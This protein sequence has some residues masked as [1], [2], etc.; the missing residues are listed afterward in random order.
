LTSL[1][2]L[3]THLRQRL[4]RCPT[5][6]LS[7]R[8]SPIR[9]CGGIP[10]RISLRRQSIRSSHRR[11]SLRAG[12][13]RQQR[14]HQQKRPLPQRKKPQ[15]RAPRKNRRCRDSGSASGEAAGSGSTTRQFFQAAHHRAQHGQ[16]FI[17]FF[18]RIPV[19]AVEI[20]A[21][22]VREAQMRCATYALLIR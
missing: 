21:P 2:N 7:Q 14:K 5:P 15:L 17:E 22:V 8:N 9:R 1:L 12:N 6:P 18:R 10:C 19:V 20:C 3:L 13:P 16:L 11:R 4:R